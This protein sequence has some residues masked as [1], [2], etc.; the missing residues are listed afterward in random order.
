ML[1]EYK[2]NKLRK[3]LRNKRISL[4]PNYRKQATILINKKLKKLIKRNNNIAIYIAKGSEVNL[5]IFIKNLKKLPVNIFYPVV[6]KNNQKRMSFIPIKT[7]K[8]IKKI[9]R[10]ENM[11]LVI[12][13]LIGADYLGNRLGQGGGFYDTSLSFTKIY[14]NLKKVGVGFDC[15][16]IKYIPNEKYDINLNYYISENNFIKY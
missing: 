11:N 10:I 13:P 2:K 6:N 12:M 1:I 7:N 8:K 5:E 3:T 15:Q 16:L 9:K 14:H 4:N